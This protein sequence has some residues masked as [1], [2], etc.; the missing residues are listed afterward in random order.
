MWKT[1]REFQD[2]KYERT[3]DGIAKITINRPEV[4]N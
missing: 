2:I 3:D 1:I 4:R